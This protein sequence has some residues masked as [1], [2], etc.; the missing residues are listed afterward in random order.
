MTQPVLNDM[1]GTEISEEISRSVKNTNDVTVKSNYIAASALILQIITIHRLP[2]ITM[3]AA[4][5][6]VANSAHSEYD[7]M[8]GIG[9]PASDFFDVGPDVTSASGSLHSDC[10]SWA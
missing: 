7:G 1:H 10:V 9:P 2:H 3:P 8:F 4:D 5:A 6:F